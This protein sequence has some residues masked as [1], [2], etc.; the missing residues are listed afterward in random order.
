MFI[1]RY[2]EEISAAKKEDGE[3]EEESF[4]VT[5]DGNSDFSE[6]TEKGPSPNVCMRGLGRKVTKLFLSL[7]PS[8]GSLSN[9]YER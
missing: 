2:K 3:T 6:S 1:L 4:P 5:Q 9:L 7:N 8:T